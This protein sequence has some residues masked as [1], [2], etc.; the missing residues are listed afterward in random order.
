MAY[1]SFS[2]IVVVQYTENL[3]SKVTAR[4]IERRRQWL[5]FHCDDKTL[6]TAVGCAVLV[7]CVVIARPSQY[8]VHCRTVRWSSAVVF[9][10]MTIGVLRI[11]RAWVD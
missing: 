3:A 10:A 9:D 11:G 6:T 4:N 8:Y 5:L 2:S 1:S 7:V